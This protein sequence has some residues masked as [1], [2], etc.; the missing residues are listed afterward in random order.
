MFN[1]RTYSKNK[2]IKFPKKQ[3]D[4]AELFG[5]IAGDGYINYYPKKY[6]SICEIVGDSRLEKDYLGIYLHNKIKKLFNI[7]P[8][9]YVKKNQNAMCLSI[10]NKPIIFFINKNGFPYGK[11][12]DIKIP[13][14]ILEN[15]SYMKRFIRGLFDTDGSLAIKKRYKIKP[16]YPVISISSKNKYPLYQVYDFLKNKL[17]INFIKESRRAFKNDPRIFV[18]Y[19]LQSS[20]FENT[21]KWFKLIKPSNKKHIDKFIKHVD[22]YIYK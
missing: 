2:H 11:K 20:G 13:N 14:W 1:Q 5:I 15:K 8:K 7:F 21:I 6:S 17:K 3:K 19:R 18:L 22:S 10:H 16:Y 9:I 4:L 12:S